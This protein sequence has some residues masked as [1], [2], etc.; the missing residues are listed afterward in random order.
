MS[1]LGPVSTDTPEAA[2][3]LPEN[4]STPPRAS[5]PRRAAKATEKAAGK[6]AGGSPGS[7]QPT[8]RA[9]RKRAAA[10]SAT[11]AEAAAAGQVGALARALASQAE[12]LA[13]L[14]TTV[15]PAGGTLG[16]IPVVDVGP[17]IEGGRWPARASVGEAVP[18]TATVFREG[19]DA[20]NASAVLLRPD[21]SVHSRVTMTPGPP[22]LDG[23]T[24]WVVPDAPGL[25]AFQ[26]EGWDDPYATWLHDAVIKVEAGVD[27]D[28]ML[29]EGA[30]L[31]EDALRQEGHG[32]AATKALEA[33]V[34][35]LR[36]ESRPPHDRLD[37]GTSQDVVRAL[38][39]NPLRRLVTASAAY[40]LRVQRE[41]ALCGSW[42]EFFPRSEGAHWDEDAQTWVSGTL[43]TAAERLPAIADMGFD[44]A[45]LT[46]VHPIGTTNRKGR[47]NTLTTEP[48]DPGSPYGIGSPDG[49]HDAIHPDL[50]TIEDFDAFVARARGL[51]I[52]V[53]MDLALQ[54][55]PDHP[56]VKDHPEWFTTRADGTIAYAEN[57]PKKYQDI[58]PVNFDNDPVGIYHEVLR[59]VLH[60]VRHGVTLFRVDNPHTKPV[61]FWEWLIAEVNRDHP[62]VIF[63]AEAF[64]RPAMMRTLA[65]VGFQQSYTYFTW[66][67][68]KKELTDYVTELSSGSHQVG[69]DGK[70]GTADYMVPSFWPTTHD[71][72]TP[73]MQY[74][75]RPAFIARAV[76]AAT[77]VP[78]WGI[79]TGYELVENVP[80]PGV[81]EQIDNEKY[82][83][84]PRDFEGALE[85]G[86]SLQPLLTRLNE[87]RR[88]HPAL[89]RL[90]GVHFHQTEDD[91]I[92]A[93]SR[94]VPAEHSPTGREDTILVVVNLDPHATRETV[95]H[96]D[97]PMLGLNWDEGFIAD[98]Q[99]SEHSWSWR[100][101]NFVRL[102]RDWP[103]H[104][105][106]IRR[107]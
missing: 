77:M 76:L 44:V 24:G 101:E 106:H 6:K 7:E 27:V 28:L 20:V 61:E 69:E 21:G 42:Y 105:F 45:Y 15:R 47:N 62:E 35:G 13:R 56:W 23:W 41:L 11:P 103:A 46:P 80:R 30:L 92:I 26:V 72:L 5:R 81:E 33:A 22:G 53:A 84:K 36:D 52:E 1:S 38:A 63:L 88:A 65:K 79:Y 19:H 55:S 3:G 66:R 32:D 102:H 58:Y 31:L 68:T 40:P 96:V 39:A 98:D 51:G 18:I 34:A 50:G 100:T 14:A 90:R 93:Y 95:V 91:Q 85:R 16:R 83:F 64:T 67:I 37:A 59:V 60:W 86:E 9:A 104:V 82:Q 10:V 73:L 49:G 74:G 75:G 87:I 57:P 2:S 48:G 71:I 12:E 4:E 25:W 8:R 94:R 97:L 89:Q 29:T 107:H 54:C 78:T 43:R 70:T 99:L 17:T